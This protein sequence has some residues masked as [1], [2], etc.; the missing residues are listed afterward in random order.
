MLDTGAASTVLPKRGSK[1]LGL[2]SKLA[3]YETVVTAEGTV[4]LPFL[5]DVVIGGM[6]LDKV[7]IMSYPKKYSR[8]G[9]LH[10]HMHGHR[11]ANRSGSRSHFRGLVPL[12]FT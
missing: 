6:N 9:N 2:T 5:R 4:K 8:T 10:A 3:Q 7:K 12:P 11:S 1:F